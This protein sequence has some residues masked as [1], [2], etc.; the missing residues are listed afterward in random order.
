MVFSLIPFIFIA[1]FLIVIV[2]IVIE[3]FIIVVHVAIIVYEFLVVIIVLWLHALGGKLDRIPPIFAI[4]LRVG[5]KL[6][7]KC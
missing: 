6:Q 7:D 1:E 4:V 2:F 5:F 3:F